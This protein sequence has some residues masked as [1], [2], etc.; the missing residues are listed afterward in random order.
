MARTL[1]QLKESVERLIQEQGADAPVAAFIFT[2]EDVFETDD[3][4]LEQHHLPP[5]DAEQ[6]LNE[7]EGFDYIYEQVFECMEDDIR[8]LKNRVTP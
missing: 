3:D 5:E 2:R 8:R 6:V 1:Q 4:T 7:L